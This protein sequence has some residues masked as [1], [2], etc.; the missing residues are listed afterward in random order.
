MSI[1]LA[2]DY[3]D[4]VTRIISDSARL[5]ILGGVEK[6]RGGMFSLTSKMDGDTRLCNAIGAMSGISSGTEGEA[7]CCIVLLSA[8]RCICACGKYDARGVEVGEEVPSIGVFMS[9]VPVKRG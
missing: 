1:A 3:I 5:L 9:S 4:Y 6:G 8:A 7:G 2:R